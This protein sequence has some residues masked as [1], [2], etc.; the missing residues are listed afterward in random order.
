M[1]DHPRSENSTRALLAC[2][3]PLHASL[4]PD[5][6]AL[7]LTTVR[8]PQ[9]TEDQLV[10]LSLLNLPSGT[11][12][13]LL[14]DLPGAR[15][16]EWS[17]TGKHLA[18]L[19]DRDHETVLA[20]AEV[21]SSSVTVLD[22][23]AHIDGP[24]VWAPDGTHV[25]VPCRRGQVIDRSRP[26]RWI[27]PFPAADGTGPLEDPPQLRLVDTATGE[28][29][30]LT[31]DDWRWA[32]PRWSPAGD[33]V[34]AAVGGDPSDRLGGQCLRLVHLDGTVECP[35]VPGGRAVVPVW[36]SDR[37]LVILV[38]E[39]HG[40]P[41]GS[42]T[43]LFLLEGDV[44]RELTVENLVGDVFG[45]C[46]S[47][48]ADLYEHVMLP[49]DR[50]VIVRTGTRGRL[51]VSTID[52]DT[53]AST[54]VLD[55][56]RACSPVALAGN[57]LV[58]TR[59]SAEAYPELATLDVSATDRG[60]RRLVG[61]ADELGEFAHVQRF[62][63]TSPDG[64]LLDGWFLSADPAPKSLPTV[65][66]IHGGP[67][68]AY[69][70]AFSLDAQALCAA[71]FGVVYTNPR[72]STG[73]GDDFAHAVHGDWAEGPSRDVLAVVDEVIDQGWSDP[74]R[75]GV[76]GNSYGGYLSAW[77]SSTTPR[78]S[79][80]V[81]ENPVTDLLGMYGTSDI[82]RRFFPAQLG[83]PPQEKLDVYMAQSP[84]LQAHHSQTPTLFVAGELDRRCPSGQAWAMHRVLCE[85]GTPSEV[86]VLPGS[87]H[88]GSTY[89]PIMG[90][91]AHDAALV[92]WMSRWL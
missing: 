65:L 44:M 43:A 84:L 58:F 30:W 75:L 37:T 90:R 68:F 57:T 73:L 9:G 59:Q 28:G 32:T 45:D 53:G 71:G 35:A 22:G 87:T 1:T 23:A 40:R 77:L 56:D 85:V 92:D 82:G 17:P 5:G 41:G 62:T 42:A 88:E 49:L 13:R 8:T 18:L 16:A 25:V 83:G 20:L 67:H 38:A 50:S 29:R 24:P 79:A 26:Y 81:I 72:G 33:R 39:P 48:L 61:F 64:W 6:T 86:L 74:D 60:E 54:T 15:M 46:A 31:D 21:E 3:A 34:A 36:L 52:I 78:F 55:G 91:L 14:L 66:I 47:E 10:E 51:G 12:Q 27:R 11:E 2:R 4:S 76:T 7:T 19:G 80:A 89:G 63:S 70:E 69:G